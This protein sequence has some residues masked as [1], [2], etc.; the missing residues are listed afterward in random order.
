M[1]GLLH[2]SVCKVI[3]DIKFGGDDDDE[4]HAEDAAPTPEEPEKDAPQSSEDVE[5]EA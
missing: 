1:V 3:F 5:K 4:T 2:R